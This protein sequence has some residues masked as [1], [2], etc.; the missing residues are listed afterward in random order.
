MKVSREEMQKTRR[1][2]VEAGAR[3]I[4][5]RGFRDATMRDIAERAKVGDATIYKYFPTKEGLL[6]GFFELRMEDLVTR[7][8]AVPDFHHYRFQEQ[9]HVVLETQLALFAPDRDFIRI[10]YQGVFLSNWLGAAEGARTTKARFLEII[11]DLVGSAVEV[12][13]FPELPCQ[14]LFYELLWE[15]TIGITYYWLDDTSPKYVRTT[16]MLDK[17]LAVLDALLASQVLSRAVDLVQFLI[18]EHVLARIPD[19]KRGLY[20][21]ADKP[22]KRPFMAE[23]APSAKRGKTKSKKR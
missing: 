14:R 21:D 10:A 23:N 9:L 16:E 19:R 22:P 7:L 2:L 11:D 15:Y 18:R 12:G 5:E 6:F 1:R 17:S 20:A 4:S 3:V 8:K 13:E